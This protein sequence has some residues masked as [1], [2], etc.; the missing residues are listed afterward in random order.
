MIILASYLSDFLTRLLNV[1]FNYLPILK[2]K[3]SVTE[4]FSPSPHSNQ[5]SAHNLASHQLLP[6]HHLP[7]V[8][9]DPNTASILDGLECLEHHCDFIEEIQIV[10]ERVAVDLQH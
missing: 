8:F 2:T 10:N 6:D 5:K 1:S 7:D 9:I 3:V 4:L